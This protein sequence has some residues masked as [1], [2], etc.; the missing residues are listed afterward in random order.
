[1][2]ANSN[3]PYKK[4]YRALVMTIWVEMMGEDWTP[5]TELGEGMRRL[6]WQYEL[7]PTTNRIHLQVR[8]TDLT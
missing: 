5:P 8:L 1:M 2:A 3:N 7:C 6:A 4:N